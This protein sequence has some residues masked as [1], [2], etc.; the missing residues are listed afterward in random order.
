MGTV[1]APGQ[2][3]RW[4][5]DALMMPVRIGLVKSFE[6]LEDRL[7]I[8]ELVRSAKRFAKKC[9]SGVARNAGLKSSNV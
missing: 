6:L 5:G 4:T 8:R 1:L 3:Y 7:H 2:D 9:A